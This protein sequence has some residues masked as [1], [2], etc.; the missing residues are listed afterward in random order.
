MSELAPA[1]LGVVLSRTG[2]I[3]RAKLV[4]P[5]RGN[6]LDWPMITALLAFVRGIA[7]DPGVRLLV[8]DGEGADFCTGDC[9]PDMGA[10][11]EA[12]R[13]RLPGGTHGAPPLPLMDLLSALRALPIPTLAV[14]QGQVCDA[15]FDLACHCDIRIAA[16]NAT[17]EDQR[18]AH[19]RFAATG[20]TYTLP[21]LIGQSQATRLL[22]F[23]E[24]ISATE[25]ERIGLIYKAVSGP[26][27][28]AATAELVD[29]LSNM[30]TRSYGVIKEQVREQ[31][32]LDYRNALMHSMAVRQTNVF[33]D[34]S[35]GQRAFIEKRPPRFTGR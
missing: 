24:R 29:K 13:H 31:L 27:L 11:P 21:R 12:Y 33:E 18:V 16:E 1:T 30:A 8:I 6:R 15:G 20:I 32:D 7:D 4:R 28:A 25:A 3:A 2:A 14:L 22:L 34:R 23:G 35:E 5:D 17:F 9:W 26:G 10:W 19:A